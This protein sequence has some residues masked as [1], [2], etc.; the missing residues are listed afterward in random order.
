MILANNQRKKK[1]QTK[2]AV[3]YNR[4]EEIQYILFCLLNIA[5]FIYKILKIFVGIT[6]NYKGY[7]YKYLLYILQLYLLNIE[8]RFL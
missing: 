3:Y 2:M 6:L 4:P 1:P 8:S 5:G 7:K